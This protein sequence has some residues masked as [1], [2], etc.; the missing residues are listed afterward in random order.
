[1]GYIPGI[2]YV[3]MHGV[4]LAEKSCKRREVL[5]EQWVALA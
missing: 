3:S 5:G 1:M 4:H 2:E